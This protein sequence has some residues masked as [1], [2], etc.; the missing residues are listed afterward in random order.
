MAERA[1]GGAYLFKVLLL[2]KSGNSGEPEL[3]SRAFELLL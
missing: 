3:Y 2:L 1:R